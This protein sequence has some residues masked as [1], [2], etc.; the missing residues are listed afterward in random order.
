MNECKHLR[1]D[2]PL[3]LEMILNGGHDMVGKKQI[4]TAAIISKG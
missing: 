3:T 4:I 2:E 1:F